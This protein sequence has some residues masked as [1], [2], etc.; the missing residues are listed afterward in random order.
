MIESRNQT[1]H[2]YN[3]ETARQISQAVVNRYYPQFTKLQKTL[4]EL[5]KKEKE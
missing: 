3:E 2:T 5:Q 4:E 1:S